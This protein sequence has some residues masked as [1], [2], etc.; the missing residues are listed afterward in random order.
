MPLARLR[1]KGRG[2]QHRPRL[3][4]DRGGAV[5]GVGDVR[6]GGLVDPLGES[7]L[8]DDNVYLSRLL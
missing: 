7:V 1:N 3:F 5:G 6:H 2:E 8:T 4:G